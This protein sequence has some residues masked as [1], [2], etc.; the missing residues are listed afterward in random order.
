MTT[1][2]WSLKQFLLSK[3]LYIQIKSPLPPAFCK[4]IL[5]S[6]GELIPFVTALTQP[7]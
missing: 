4:Q 6:F 1:T 7:K 3:C 5:P 2:E